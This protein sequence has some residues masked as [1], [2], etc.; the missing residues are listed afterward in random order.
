MCVLVCLTQ[1][2]LTVSACIFACQSSDTWD[3]RDI[4]DVNDSGSLSKLDLSKNHLKSEGLSAVS[5]ALK[6]TSIKQLNIA[7]NNL[8]YNTQGENDM[9]GVIKF[10]EDMKDM[11]SLS[12]INLLKNGIPIQ[13]AQELVKIKE[14]KPI[15]KSL[16]GLTMDETELDFSSQSLRAGDAVLLASDIQ[17]MGS[18]SKLKM[19]R[20]ELPVQEI[21]TAT[22]LDLSNKGL[23]E[24][25]AIVIAVL[26]TVC[27][28][29]NR[30]VTN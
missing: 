29:Q 13:H 10:A 26:I 19:D 6:S 24:L 18:L 12:C 27:K 9:S 25:D 14:S 15:L 4:L 21:K 22:E 17:D 2:C 30:F 23:G 11:G 5:E 28:L 20:Y 3:I 8:M 16:C 7:E 1:H